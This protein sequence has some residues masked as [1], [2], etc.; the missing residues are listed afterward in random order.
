MVF[1]NRVSDILVTNNY[2]TMQHTGLTQRCSNGSNTH[3]PGRVTFF[4]MA[5]KEGISTL[6][7]WP[8]HI[9]TVI[10]A[11]PQY[12]T[13]ALPARH[14]HT[15]QQHTQPPHR[16]TSGGDREENHLKFRPIASPC[17]AEEFVY[18]K[19]CCSGATPQRRHTLARLSYTYATF[20]GFQT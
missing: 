1:Q 9:S 15:P 3:L 12:S 2:N 18:G 7:S 14:A 8:L 13:P 6:R 5:L 4:T 17:A 16:H 10:A 19:G 11:I 20:I